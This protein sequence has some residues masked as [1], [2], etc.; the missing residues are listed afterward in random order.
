MKSLASDD[1]QMSLKLYLLAPISELINLYRSSNVKRQFFVIK[2]WMWNF[3]WYI[4]YISA[5]N[6]VNSFWNGKCNN[7]GFSDGLL[8]FNLYIYSPPLR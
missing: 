7:C 2:A 1:N 6:W 5:A 4:Q 3:M 8:I